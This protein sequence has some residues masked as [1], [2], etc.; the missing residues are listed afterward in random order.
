MGHINLLNLLFTDRIVVCRCR[1]F[2]GLPIDS[3]NESLIPL[4]S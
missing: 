4:I 2:I 1:F 3:G